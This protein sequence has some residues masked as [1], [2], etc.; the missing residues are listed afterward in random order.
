M[1][2]G[3]P[4]LER[5]RFR[6]RSCR[7]GRLAWS[8]SASGAGHVAGVV[9]AG[10]APLPE[11]VMSQGSSSLERLRFRS[12]SCRR[13][14][15]HWSG[16]AFRAGHVAGVVFTGAAPLPE[17][18]MSRGSP[19]LERLRFRSRKGY[20]PFKNRSISAKPSG[21][22]M[23]RRGD[24]AGTPISCPAAANSGNQSVS[25]DHGAGRFTAIRAERSSR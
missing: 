23:S 21:V 5:L 11:P 3:S 6:S 13:G 24:A 14:R 10:A 7:G 19:W 20:L 17:P 2:R 15:L 18:V 22:P 1:L 16:S 9:L 12:R 25:S 8:G 4:W